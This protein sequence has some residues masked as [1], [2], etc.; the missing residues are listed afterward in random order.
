MTFSLFGNHYKNLTLYLLWALVVI[1]MVGALLLGLLYFGIGKTGSPTTQGRTQD[2]TV[3]GKASLLP[4]SDSI[5]KT[6]AVYYTLGG[7]IAE[8]NSKEN[9]IVEIKL[10]SKPGDV[11]PRVFTISLAQAIFSQKGTN[12]PGDPISELKKG[13]QIE[14][15]L[16]VDLKSSQETVTQV[17]LD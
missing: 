15:L 9:G 6:A 17:F 4:A 14:F 13:R 8:V 10:E 1:L 16:T 2:S 3:Q 11:Y 12:F 7:K 5:V